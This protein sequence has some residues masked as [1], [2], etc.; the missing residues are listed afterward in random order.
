ML[1]WQ[2]YSGFPSK[3]CSEEILYKTHKRPV[4]LLFLT[5]LFDKIGEFLNGF[6]VVYEKCQNI[7]PPAVSVPIVW[8]HTECAEM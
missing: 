8:T 6:S 3:Y 4:Q 1:T 5:L 7:N 2:R